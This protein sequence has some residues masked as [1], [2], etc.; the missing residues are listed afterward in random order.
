M[1]Q[2][3]KA[4]NTKGK[5]SYVYA[6]IGVALVLFLFGIVGWFFLNI[7]KTGDYFKENIQVHAYLNR[8]AQKRVIDSATI[9]IQN[10]SAIKS[11][12][13][14]TKEK[15]VKIYEAE[16]DT[17]WKSFITAN[18]LPESIDYYV[19]AKYVEKKSLD[20][21]AA[22]IQENYPGLVSEFQFPQAIVTGVSKFA[23]NLV[24]GFLIAAILLTILVIFSIDNTIR[25]AMYSNRFLIKTMQMVGATRW[26]IARPINI[27]SIINGL[28]AA[29][30]AIALLMGFIFLIEA[31]RPEIKVLRDNKS[32]MLLFA[33]IAFLGVT[34]NLLSTHRA[35]I[36]YLKMKLDELY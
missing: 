12:E 27:R 24:I 31:F 26:F 16:N 35:V 6:I 4:S 1:A 25:L 13:H 29:C 7:R 22:T 14:I 10:M 3:G 18:P 28:I 2:F 23:R 34:I 36:K 30:L 17:I 8:D 21:I 5:P 11:V 33:S 20:S 19:K 32:M 15:A 9:F